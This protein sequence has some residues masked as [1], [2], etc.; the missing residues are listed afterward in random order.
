MMGHTNGT[1]K[2]SKLPWFKLYARDFLFDEKVQM[3]SNAQVGIYIKLLCFQ[4]L[5][6]SIP[7]QCERIASVMPFDSDTYAKTARPYNADDL[8]G[9]VA[10]C[11][12]PHP[13]LLDRMVN[14]KLHG[15]Q[16]EEDRK[17]QQNRESAKKRWA[18]TNGVRPHHVGNTNAVRTNMRTHSQRIQSQSQSQSQSQKQKK[19]LSSSQKNSHPSG[20]GDT[21]FEQFW[22]AYPARNGKKLEK[23]ETRRRFL[24]L[25]AE[26]R[27]A[28]C[29]AATHYAASDL[30]TQGLATKDPKRF[31]R[32]GKGNE[33]WRDWLTPE[34]PHRATPT[35][36][37]L[38]AAV[39]W[40]EVEAHRQGG[41]VPYTHPA[42]QVTAR[43]IGG[44]FAG[45][46][47]TTSL[48]V[49]RGQFLKMF[50]D[51]YATCTEA[52]V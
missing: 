38:T 52:P 5:E 44:I 32:D 47:T 21:L 42:I 26:D 48:D 1:G 49:K 6:G 20:E 34:T 37:T 39:A 30:V 11:F 8:A 50:P 3:M 46:I 12:V 35:S 36:G 28:A 10:Q 51:I 45:D 31:L 17:C 43:A 29:T 9:V 14:M 18:D 19:T 41:K 27:A 40:A 15:I 25:T 4:W 22:K 24:L 23:T 13:D 2:V 7:T 33:P 16:C